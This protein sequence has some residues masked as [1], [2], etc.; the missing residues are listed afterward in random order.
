LLNAARIDGAGE[1]RIFWSVVLPVIRP[2][3]VTLAVFSFLGTWNDF[4]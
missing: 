2:I 3:L 1:F 4:L